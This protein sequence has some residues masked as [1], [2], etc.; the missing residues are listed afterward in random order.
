MTVRL[1]CH[2]SSPPW[3]C[4]ESV[5]HGVLHRTHH[6]DLAHLYFVIHG[7]S[8]LTVLPLVFS[9]TDE[10]VARPIYSNAFFLPASI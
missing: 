1:A 4:T 5:L 7:S 2:W 10:C 6:L 3:L 8:T 9:E